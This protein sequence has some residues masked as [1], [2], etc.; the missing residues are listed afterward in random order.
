MLFTNKERSSDALGPW[1]PSVG[2]QSLI[3]PFSTRKEKRHREGRRH[4]GGLHSGTRPGEGD[5]PGIW[6]WRPDHPPP[7]AGGSATGQPSSRVST[8]G[9]QEPRHRARV[10]GEGARPECPGGRGCGLGCESARP[11]AGSPLG[12]SERVRTLWWS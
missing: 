4:A 1:Q 12:V 6:P 2:L 8:R 10:S 5:R 9:R 3:R 7:G 11:R